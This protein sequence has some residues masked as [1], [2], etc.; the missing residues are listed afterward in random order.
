[1]HATFRQILELI[2][3]QYYKFHSSKNKITLGFV[4][5]TLL[6]NASFELKELFQ[7]TMPLPYEST[8]AGRSKDSRSKEIKKKGICTFKVRIYKV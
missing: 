7:K 8:V 4:K 6:F 2:F 5:E 3:S 1:M